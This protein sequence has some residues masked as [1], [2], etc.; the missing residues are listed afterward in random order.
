[1]DDCEVI[2][3]DYLTR[4]LGFKR[5]DR[6]PE[7]KAKFP[8][9]L[10]VDIGV[11]AEV[12]RLNQNWQ[13][14]RPGTKGKGVFES[15]HRIRACTERTLG[16]LGPPTGIVSWVVEIEYGQPDSA[17]Q[18]AGQKAIRQFLEAFRDSPTTQTATT[19]AL[20]DDFKLELCSAGRLHKNGFILGACNCSE[21]GG[22]LGPE[23]TRNVQICIDEKTDRW[24]T[25]GIPRAKYSGWWL[26]LVDLI[27]HGRGGKI[28][29]RPQVAPY[30]WDKIVLISPF[31][32]TRTFEVQVPF[33]SQNS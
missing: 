26:L 21:S 9:Y 11:A 25:S 15:I 2:A 32:H 6:E 33:V 27:S 30:N 19:V 17:R 14:P 7:G 8:D 29:V 1:M 20:F 31:D 5:V 28:Q 22:W 12:R 16:S 13:S 24:K 4:H 23:L 3:R 10:I 18:K